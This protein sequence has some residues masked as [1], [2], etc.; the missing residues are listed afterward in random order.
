M[1]WAA[2]KTALWLSNDPPQIWDHSRLDPITFLLSI[3]ILSEI[4]NHLS[5][6]FECLLKLTL[7]NI[8]AVQGQECGA[9][10]SPLYRRVKIHIYQNI[11]KI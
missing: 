11:A 10:A 3:L 9:A 2:V 6:F 1:Q 5:N 4:F 8:M 7:V